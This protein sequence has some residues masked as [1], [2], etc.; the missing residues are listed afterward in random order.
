MPIKIT[1]EFQNTGRY[2]YDFGLCSTTKGF[3][4]FV[5]GQDAHYFGIWAN[6]T[7]LIIVT[8]AEGDITVEE[9]DTIPEFV[10]AI[11]K[12]KLS[13]ENYGIRFIGI[14]PGFNEPLKERF[15]EIGLG[16]LLH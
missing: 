13:Y 11:R 7:K 3:A 6:P 9:A 10:D 4:Q 8:Y 16:D 12:L 14:D 15:K 5:T 1:R 2:F